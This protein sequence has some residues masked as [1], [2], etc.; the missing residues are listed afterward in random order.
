MLYYGF[1]IIKNSA[2]SFNV[3]NDFIKFYPKQIS[4]ST[5]DKRFLCVLVLQVQAKLLQTLLP[6]D[7]MPTG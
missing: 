1:Q 3:L 7:A 4:D 6:L 5:A 2:N